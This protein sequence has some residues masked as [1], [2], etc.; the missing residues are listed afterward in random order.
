[1][2]KLFFD[3]YGI[4][5]ELHPY[6]QCSEEATVRLMNEAEWEQFM[7]CLQDLNQLIQ[8]DKELVERLVNV[9]DKTEREFALAL[10]PYTNRYLQALYVRHLLPDFMTKRF[11]LIILNLIRCESH[12][13]RL[14]QY[15]D[16]KICTF[17]K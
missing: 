17:K 15:I 14:L 13:E 2:V 11:W 7:E 6:T 5:F 12:R 1:M 3:N 16:N 8:N 9:V 10:C 4:S